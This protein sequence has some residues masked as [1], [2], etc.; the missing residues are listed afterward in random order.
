MMNSTAGISI[1][2]ITEKSRHRGTL[3][4]NTSLKVLL[5]EHELLE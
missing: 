3:E 5:F 2:R 1:R 4:K